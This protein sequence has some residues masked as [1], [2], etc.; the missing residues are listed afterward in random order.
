MAGLPVTFLYLCVAIA[1]GGCVNGQDGGVYRE[2]LETVMGHP[3]FQE[4]L[5][6][7]L[8]LSQ[9]MMVQ[10]R[11]GPELRNVSE[12]CAACMVRKHPWL[13]INNKNRVHN[14]H[15]TKQHATNAQGYLMVHLFIHKYM[16]RI[17]VKHWSWTYCRIISILH[18]SY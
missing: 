18:I 9:G 14:T 13:I 6:Q 5:G 7:E 12:A 2:A 17:C 8:G 1:L 15:I 4:R 16:L 11:D 10:L 3:H